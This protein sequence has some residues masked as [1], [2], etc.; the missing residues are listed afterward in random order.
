[1]KQLFYHLL[2]TLVLI[3][4]PIKAALIAAMALAMVDLVAGIWAAKARKEPITSSGLK[5]TILKVLVYEVV[6]MLGYITEK[7]MTGDLVPIVKVLAGLIG[8]TELKSI[9][10]NLRDITGVPLLQLISKKLGQIER[11]DV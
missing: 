5:R 11:D 2:L 8:V 9:V 4:A 3:F 7:Y 10:E 1:M 6:I